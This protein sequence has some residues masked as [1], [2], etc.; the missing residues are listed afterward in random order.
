MSSSSNDGLVVIRG[1][2]PGLLFKLPS[3][4]PMTR[5]YF[6]GKVM[7]VLSLAAQSLLG[8]VFGWE[9]L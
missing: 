8:T 6:V 3:G 5:P 2:S 9:L 7:E 1:N 4:V